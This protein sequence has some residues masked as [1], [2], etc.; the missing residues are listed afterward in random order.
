MTINGRNS[1]ACKTQLSD[2]RGTVRIEPLSGMNVI[3]DLVVDWDPA[4]VAYKSISPHLMNDSPAP[5]KERLQSQEVRARYDAAATCI[6][7]FACTSS[8]PMAWTEN[9]YLGPF[10]LTRLARFVHDD[11]D[12]A[13]DYRLDMAAQEEGVWR[14]RTAFRCTDSCPKAIPITD[15]I[16][17]L[18][19]Q[20]FI[21]SLRRAAR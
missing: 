4:I 9:A 12:T 10:A 17:Q 1:L 19:R 2:L 5:D 6:L 11:R 16:M 8:C 3:K 15:L 7:C 14:C 18:R 21:R 13:T 20:I